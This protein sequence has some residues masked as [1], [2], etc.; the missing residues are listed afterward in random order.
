MAHCTRAISLF[1]P[2]FFTTKPTPSQKVNSCEFCF[3]A[4]PYSYFWFMKQILVHFLLALPFFGYTQNHYQ[5]KLSDTLNETRMGLWAEGDYKIYIELDIVETSFRNTGK[6]FII[7]A[8]VSDNYEDS[9]AAVYNLTAKRYLKAVDQLQNAE[10]GFDLR[11]LVVY[12]GPENKKENLGNS[13]AVESVVKQLLE[14][15]RA[16]VYYKEK[17]VFNLN[18]R[19]EPQGVGLDFGY[20]I[21]IYFE[22]VENYIYKYHKILGW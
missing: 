10:N 16:A 4:I 1:V 15:G 12:Y 22:D 19:D 5:I 7:N 13:F 2:I 8:G 14:N 21:T 11:K 17:R 20:T 9:F 3:R 6:G 18:K